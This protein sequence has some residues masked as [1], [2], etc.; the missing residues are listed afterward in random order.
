[1]LNFKSKFIPLLVTLSVGFKLKVKWL[2]LMPFVVS[3]M[4]VKSSKF[5]VLVAS[6]LNLSDSVLLSLF[7]IFMENP[8]F[9]SFIVLPSTSKLKE[10]SCLLSSMIAGLLTVKVLSS[11]DI[12]IVKFLS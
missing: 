12:S 10:I 2:F 6:K 1:M 8:R 4:S 9:V 3:C 11:L 5:N 7:P